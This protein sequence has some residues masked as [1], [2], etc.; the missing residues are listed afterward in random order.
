MNAQHGDVATGPGWEL[1]CGRWQEALAHVTECDALITDPPYSERTHTGHHGAADRGQWTN[2]DGERVDVCPRRGIEY[3]HWTTEDVVAF[4]CGWESRVSGWMVCQTSHDMIGD[5]ARVMEAVGRYTFHP[6]PAVITG[7]TVRL[8]GDG[9]SSWAIYNVVSRTKT[10]D[11]QRWGTLPGAYIGTR[12]GER[13]MGA[14]D[15]VIVGGKPLWLMRAIIRDYTRPGDLVVDPCAG[16]GT[17]LLAAVM[18]GRRAIGAEMDPAT[19]DKAVAR[20]RKGFTTPLPGMEAPRMEQAALVFPE[21]PKRVKVE[22]SPEAL[23]A[24]HEGGQE[25][26]DSLAY[27]DDGCGWCGDANCEGGCPDNPHNLEACS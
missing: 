18:E 5:Y 8:G 9:P 24:L 12:E 22:P 23:R 27:A 11:M 10:R 2:Y 4:V 19:F 6:V 25:W 16:G 20:L 21:A 17:T 15:M 13:K 7:M 26:I 14:D 1:R 3:D